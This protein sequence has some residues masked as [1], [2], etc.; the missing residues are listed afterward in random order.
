[1]PDLP[2]SDVW[3]LSETDIFTRFG[4]GFL[5]LWHGD[6]VNAEIYI[7]QSLKD[8]EQLGD[9]TTLS[10]AI[11][12]LTVI[13]RKRGLVDE[14]RVYADRLLQTASIGNM[15]EYIASAYGHQ[16]WHA[17]RSGDIEKAHSLAEEGYHLLQGVPI[18]GVIV[19]IPLWPLIAV[20]IS[21]GQLEDAINHV[22]V[23]IGPTQ[24]PQPET[25]AAQLQ[26][27]LD[28]W[29]EGNINLSEQ[30]LLHASQ[31]ARQYGYV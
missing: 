3:T 8:S 11:A 9:V 2:E 20:E 31:I 13:Y 27:A 5:Y 26:L 21:K 18:G 1:M 4:I 14:V 25:V 23:L 7:R 29:A 6:L 19:W 22:R 12:Y 10:R 24:Q 16:A 28:A 15:I 17:N 30:H